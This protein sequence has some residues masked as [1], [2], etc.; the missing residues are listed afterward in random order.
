MASRMASDSAGNAIATGSLMDCPKP[1][2]AAPMATILP[3]SGRPRIVSARPTTPGMASEWDERGRTAGSLAVAVSSV[4][5]EQHRC[6]SHPRDYAA[7]GHGGPDDLRRVLV[8]RDRS[9]QYVDH[10]KSE[11]RPVGMV[12]AADRLQDERKRATEIRQRRDAVEEVKMGQGA[13]RR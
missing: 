1:N 12:N 2:S 11:R 13:I 3:R 9:A 7:G 5:H 10:K 8:A 6:A 4:M